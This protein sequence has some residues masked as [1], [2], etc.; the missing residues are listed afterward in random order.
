MRTDVTD[1][2]ALHFVEPEDEI[3]WITQCVCGAKF[4]PWSQHI[5]I[6]DTEAWECPECGARLCFGTSTRVFKIEYDKEPEAAKD[7]PR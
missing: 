4:E 2:T 7:E 1:K 5:S 6:Y 3:A